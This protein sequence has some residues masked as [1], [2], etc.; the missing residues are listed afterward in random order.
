MY[1]DRVDFLRHIK[2]DSPRIAEIGVEFGGYTD[3][4]INYF[5]SPEVHLVDLWS[6]EGNEDPY[7]KDQPE[8]LEYALQQI[9]RKY[10]DDGRVRICKGL[11]DEWVDKF[12]DGFF[13]W[14]YIDACHTYEAVKNDITKWLPKVKK[15]G[16]ISGHDFFPDPN[17]IV[18]SSFGVDQ[19]VVEIFG[20]DF[21][22]TNEFYYKTWYHEV[23]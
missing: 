11:A 8:Q 12:D 9:N 14:I 21:S 6:T 13:D 2:R 3:Q 19:A 7:F 18:Y 16:I 5:E 1:F 17:N 23:K 10:G 15:G 20:S 4:Y 22:L